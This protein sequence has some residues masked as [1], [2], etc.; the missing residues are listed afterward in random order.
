MRADRA[1]QRWA[2]ARVPWDANSGNKPPVLFAYSYAARD[3]LRRA[4]SLGWITVLGQIDL[5]PGEWEIVD[6]VAGRHPEFRPAS[7]APPASYFEGWREELALADHVIVNSQWSADAML[8]EGVPIG[9]LHVTPVPFEEPGLVPR[10]RQ[11]PGRFTNQRPLRVLFLGQANLRKGI[12]DL[13]EAMRA[14]DGEPIELVM[15]G[16]L[17][18]TLP[19]W[20][21]RLGNVRLLGQV[22]REHVG[23]VYQAADV[24][25][26][27]THSDGFGLTQV[28]AQAWALPLIASRHCGHVVQHEVNGLL[29]DRVDSDAIRAALTRCLHQPQELATWARASRVDERFSLAAAAK[30][31]AEML[32]A[33]WK[34]GRER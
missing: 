12:A 3:L 19:D 6:G 22:A 30:G 2:L 21:R 33:D 23:R 18:V 26:L 7:Q 16:R 24:F 10:S 8:A 15:A 4:K 29:L 25:I 28:E 11:L 32:G 27:P 17:Q 13:L 14:M 20:A 9:K 34:N 5:G 1:F 31:F